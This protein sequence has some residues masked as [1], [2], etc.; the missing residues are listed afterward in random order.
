MA[1]GVCKYCGQTISLFLP[2][3]KTADDYE[4]QDLIDMATGKCACD[5]AVKESNRLVQEIQ[6]VKQIGEVFEQMILEDPDRTSVYDDQRA[7][8]ENAVRMVCGMTIESAQIRM[9]AHS[10]FAIGIKSNGSLRIRRTYKG[11]EEWIF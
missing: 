8:I 2:D 10:S 11:T 1:I 5:E 3:G 7:L 9:D 6:A 4:P